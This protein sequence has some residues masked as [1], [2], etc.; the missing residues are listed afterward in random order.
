VLGWF[1]SQ[2]TVCLPLSEA[3]LQHLLGSKTYVDGFG[4]L[5]VSVWK[6]T[7]FSES[8]AIK[9]GANMPGRTAERR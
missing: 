2:L 3:L 8:L 7:F 9:K 4:E 5:K 1:G 6:S